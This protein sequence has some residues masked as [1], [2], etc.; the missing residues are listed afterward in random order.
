MYVHVSGHLKSFQGVRQLVVFSVRHVRY[1]H[2]VL[3][4]N[5]CAV[6]VYLRIWYDSLG[7]DENC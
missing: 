1:S 4:C 5:N 3:Y 2:F 6:A 7:P